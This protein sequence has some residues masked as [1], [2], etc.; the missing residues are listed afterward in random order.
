MSLAATWGLF[1]AFAGSA[2]T[3]LLTIWGYGVVALGS[4]VLLALLSRRSGLAF[5][6]RRLPWGLACYLG[7]AVVSIIWSAYRVGT[8]V[9]LLGL[10]MCTAVGIFVARH[11][12][13]ADVLTA[14]QRAA[15]GVLGLSLLFEVFVSLVIRHPVLPFFTD[16]GDKEPPLLAYWSRDVLLEGGRIQGLPGNANL[17]A[18]VAAVALI[19]SAARLATAT[20][21][22]EAL[23]SV[24]LALLS[25]WLTRSSTVLVALIGVGVILA[26][27]TVF[28]ALRPGRPRQF[29]AAA[30]LLITA[31]GVGAAIIHWRV[32]LSGF[33]KSADLTGRTEIWAKVIERIAERPVLGWGF[34][35][36]W[37]SWEP[38]FSEFVIRNGV[39]QLQAH[40]AWLDVTMQLG[41]VGAVVFLALITQT[42]HG[43]LSLLPHRVTRSTFRTFFAA[44]APF[45]LLLLLVLQS[46]TESRPLIESGWVLLVILAIKPRVPESPP[47]RGRADAE[48]ARPHTLS[49]LRSRWARTSW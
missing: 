43:T 47:A 31:G 48:A 17:L 44:A 39:R 21:R 19:V 33:G 2:W 10:L 35:S 46:L 15:G 20:H 22:A 34:S 12:S 40:N 9:T 29:G 11:L 25:L 5:S 18:F 30:I 23:G 24:L 38:Q 7:L 49:R 32:I 8:V 41:L 42:T 4:V 26:A 14:I 28:L 45:S 16:Y 13:W 1:V 3:N 6:P 27:I 37:A 36:P